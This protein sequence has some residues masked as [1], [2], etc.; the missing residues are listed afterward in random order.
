M[1]DCEPHQT[2]EVDHQGSSDRVEDYEEGEDSE[3][4]KEE[5]GDDVNNDD[6]EEEEEGGGGVVEASRN[7]QS[8]TVTLTDPQ[9]LDCMICYNPLTIPV[10]QLR[11]NNGIERIHGSVE[12]HEDE[13][14]SEGDEDDDDEDSHSDSDGDG[15]DCEKEHN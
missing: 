7:D 9:V 15:D 14:D 13:E 10:F 1:M 6:D 8:I 12:D 4:D 2:N 5:E 11:M 3:E